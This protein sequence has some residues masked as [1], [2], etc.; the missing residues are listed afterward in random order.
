MTRN[1]RKM[2]KII[3]YVPSILGHLWVHKWVRVKF[4]VPEYGSRFPST[5]PIL[6]NYLVPGSRV[7]VQVPEYG[8]RSRSWPNI[9]GT[10]PPMGWVRFFAHKTICTIIF[11]LNTTCV[12]LLPFCIEVSLPIAFLFWEKHTNSKFTKLP[13]ISLQTLEWTFD[14]RQ[15]IVWI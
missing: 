12:T 8:S 15:H 4:K 1:G 2:A 14:H 13:S 6:R 11:H 5:G 9:G 10:Y 7:W 3:P